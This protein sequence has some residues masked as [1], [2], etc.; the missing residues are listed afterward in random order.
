MY[1][2]MI[3]AVLVMA[4]MMGIGSVWAADFYKGREAYD[5]GDYATALR[6]W[7]PLAERGVA[8]AQN[9]LGVIYHKGLGVLQDYGKAMHWY[10][11]AAKQGY[12]T[13]QFNLGLMY[14]LGLGIAEDYVS[15]HVWY[16]L[17]SANGHSEAH[18]K[19]DSIAVLLT[20]R[21]IAKARKKAEKCLKTNYR[22][23]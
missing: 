23:C 4:V 22:E 2:R 12:A 15:A 1:K 5:R 10:Q 16:N 11:K 13:A 14:T 20:N 9:N 8:E 6:E 18:K 21:Q 7:R 19:R 3:F 17:A